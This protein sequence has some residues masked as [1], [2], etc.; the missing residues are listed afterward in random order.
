MNPMIKRFVA[1]EFMTEAQ[2]QYIEDAIMR[3]ETVIVSGHRSAGIRPL[4]ATLMAVAKSNFDS[5]QVKSF[6]DL[7]KEGDYLLIPGIDNIDFEKLISDAMA[8]PNTAFISI[9]EPEHPYSI[10]KLLR[11]VY[12]TNKDTSKVYQVLECDKIN[13]VPKLTKLTRMSINDKGR[14]ERVDFKE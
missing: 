8:K 7:E 3:K 2:G 13:D 12:K 10:M 9:K 11:N 14:V 6:E 4:M 5:V 1:Q